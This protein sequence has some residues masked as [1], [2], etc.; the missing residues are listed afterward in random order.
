MGHYIHDII[1][2]QGTSLQ[3][4][5][6]SERANILNGDETEAVGSSRIRIKQGVEGSSG[7]EVITCVS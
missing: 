3:T 1:S 6:Q 2:P 5:P 7:F 4:R